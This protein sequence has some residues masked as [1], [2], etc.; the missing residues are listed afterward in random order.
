MPAR[1]SSS[2]RCRSRRNRTAAGRRRPQLRDR[3]RKLR[4]DVAFRASIQ[5]MLPRSVLISPLCARKRTAGRGPGREGVRGEALMDER[6]RRFVA[7]VQKVAVVRREL[8]TEHHALVDNGRGPT[9][10]LGNIP[11]PP[12]RR[13]QAR[14]ETTLRMISSAALYHPQGHLQSCL[15]GWRPGS[16]GIL[17]GVHVGPHH[18]LQGHGSR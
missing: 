12:G 2:K 18:C 15:C 11:R 7:C 6:Q 10:T 17:S 4:V 8:A 13:P 1:T 9:S 14:L 5:L 3:F 16:R